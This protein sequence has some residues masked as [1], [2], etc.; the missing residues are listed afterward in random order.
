MLDNIFPGGD[1]P[2]QPFVTREQC[3]SP[4]LGSGFRNRRTPSRWFTLNPN[5]TQ[6]VAWKWKNSVQRELPLHGIL[7]S[8]RRW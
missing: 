5:L 4:A 8:T 1:S 7:G 3:E 6:P 2:S